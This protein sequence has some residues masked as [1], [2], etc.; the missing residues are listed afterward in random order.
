MVAHLIALRIIDGASSVTAPI[1]NLVKGGL[2]FM[3]RFIGR[4]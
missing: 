2:R 1:T 4:R 3:R